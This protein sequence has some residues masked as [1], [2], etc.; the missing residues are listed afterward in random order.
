[1]ISESGGRKDVSMRRRDDR[2]SW[3]LGLLCAAVLTAIHLS[4]M[5]TLDNRDA[6]NAVG[7]PLVAYVI[8]SAA[9]ACIA[10]WWTQSWDAGM[11]AGCIT[12]LC[13]GI[14]VYCTLLTYALIVTHGQLFAGRGFAVVALLAFLP[15]CL[16]GICISIGGALLGCKIA[17]VEQ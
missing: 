10:S 5:F 8:V 6:F 3:L 15:S 13:S 11:K 16:L 12:G 4:L 1:M 9:S 2:K 7:V 17:N 14:A